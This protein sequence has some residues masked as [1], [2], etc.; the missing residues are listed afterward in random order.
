MCCGGASGLP[1]I[2]PPGRALFLQLIELRLT[3]FGQTGPYARRPGFARIFE[4]M[5][6]FTHLPAR[7]ESRLTSR[8]P[9]TAEGFG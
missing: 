6:G 7:P 5:S 1:V 9:Q 8:F 4:A 2:V 3:G